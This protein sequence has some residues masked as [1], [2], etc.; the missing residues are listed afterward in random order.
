M[1]GPTLRAAGNFFVLL[2]RITAMPEE[3]AAV[4]ART[5]AM[6]SGPPVLDASGGFAFS[7][8][9]GGRHLTGCI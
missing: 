2:T 8:P 5:Q 4:H 9:R 7:N 1:P 6:F 3:S